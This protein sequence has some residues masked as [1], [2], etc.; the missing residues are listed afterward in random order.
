MDDEMGV[1]LTEAM[2][3]Q[4]EFVIDVIRAAANI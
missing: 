2:L 3:S 1:A 4:P